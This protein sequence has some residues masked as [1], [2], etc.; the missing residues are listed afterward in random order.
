MKYLCHNFKIVC[1]NIDLLYHKLRKIVRIL[2]FKSSM[3]NFLSFVNVNLIDIKL[4]IQSIF[5]NIGM[6]IMVMTYIYLAYLFLNTNL[7]NILS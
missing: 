7:S 1:S 5:F 6:H 4:I 2:K 3:L